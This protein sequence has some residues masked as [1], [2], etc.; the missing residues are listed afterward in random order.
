MNTG[1]PNYYDAENA[2]ALCQFAGEAYGAKGNGQLIIDNG[3][4]DTRA[5]MYQDATDVVVAFRGTIDLENWMTD[6][7]ARM[8]PLHDGI[9]IHAGFYRALGSVQVEINKI[10]SGQGYE[11]K[12]LWLTGH[13]LGG[14]LAK[15]FAW[16]LA[17]ALGRV[18]VSGVYTFGEPRQ[19]NTAY[20]DSYE[21]LLFDRTFR[22]VNAADLV[23]HVPWL[24]GLYRHC[25]HEVF[26][27]GCAGG[28]ATGQLQPYRVD[29]PLWQYALED[30]MAMISETVN[31][32]EAEQWI[33]DHS[34]SK[35]QALFQG[36][37]AEGRRQKADIELW[38]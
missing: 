26:Y 31:P 28:C 37:K 34:I 10:I 23:P 5:V 38:Q 29:R 36:Q 20:R 21:A 9:R 1:I 30:V 33:A 7:D 3:S 8:V 12:R 27:D 19:G 25:G 13:S 35:Y 22:V 2:A 17:Q 4:T 16:R 11:A 14:A 15:L 32:T 24:C 18:V 6:L